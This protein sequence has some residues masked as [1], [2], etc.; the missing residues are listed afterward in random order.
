MTTQR[1]G[2]ASEILANVL[3]FTLRCFVIHLGKVLAINLS[4]A[5][6]IEIKPM[7]NELFTFNIIKLRIHFK[8]V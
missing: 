5:K 2:Y 8:E 1:S 7:S 4:V 6:V 3:S